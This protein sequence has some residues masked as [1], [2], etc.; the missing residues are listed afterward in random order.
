[1]AFQQK[2]I[3]YLVQLQ[4]VDSSL[5]EIE[6]E[7]G[8]LPKN[9]QYF[10]DKL[11]NLQNKISTSK[12]RISEYKKAVTVQQEKEK[13]AKELI[14]KY[15]REQKKAK[16]DQEYDILEKDL[17]SEKVELTLIQRRL[18]GHHKII[19]EEKGKVAE[20]K[21][22]MENL[23]KALQEKKEALALIEE[24]SAAKEKALLEKRSSVVQNLQPELCKIYEEIKQYKA[25]V[26]VDIVNDIC[27]GC[28]ITIPVQK[29]LDI[30][31]YEN[32]FTCEH[33]ASIFANVKEIETAP[34][35]G[36]LRRRRSAA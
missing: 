33:C 20:M 12:S 16:N 22:E 1:M 4:K 31:K 23:N 14:K 21:M 35:S 28:F 9:I 30:K 6:I 32:I 18:K 24:S 8:N 29:Q 11:E 13:K 17:A 2:Q 26:V 34:T 27:Q 10:K 5:Q 36:R 19:E 7:K 3:N 25:K 15:E